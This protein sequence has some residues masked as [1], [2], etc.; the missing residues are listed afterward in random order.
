MI[1]L[2]VRWAVPGIE[3]WGA[4]GMALLISFYVVLAFAACLCLGFGLMLW[5]IH[6]LFFVQRE[7]GKETA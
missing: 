3:I 2:G 4:K 7:G 6:T 5:G 1:V